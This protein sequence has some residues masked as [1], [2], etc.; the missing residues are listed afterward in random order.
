[1]KKAPK[2]PSSSGSKTSWTL[3]TSVQAI[4][5]TCVSPSN[6]NQP[7]PTDNDFLNP[8]GFG[9]FKLVLVGFGY[10]VPQNPGK[11]A[12]IWAASR[13]LSQPKP[14][15][16]TSFH[17]PME[18]NGTI[19]PQNGTADRST[20]PCSHRGD[21]VDS[22][23][24]AHLEQN[25]TISFQSGTT[26]RS[27]APSNHRGDEVDSPQT[28]DLE[29]NGTISFQTG[30]TH[31]FTTPRSHRGDEVA[32]LQPPTWNKTERFRSKMERPSPRNHHLS[33]LRC[34]VKNFSAK[35]SPKPL[36]KH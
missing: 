8:V 32:S 11:T 28:A 34:M 13:P 12:F 17:K 35:N 25:G 18:Q 3:P 10:Q 36:Q 16:F 15:A 23:Q 19:S 21:E 4:Y 20:A 26:H 29:Q 2:S 6:Q 9:W 27:T 5:W 24:T 33:T 7:K 1:V 31:R 30:T 22:P 14:T